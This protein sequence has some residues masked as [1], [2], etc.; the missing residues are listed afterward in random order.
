MPGIIDI[1]TGQDHPSI[2]LQIA[3]YAELAVNGKQGD[4][5]FDKESH[6]YKVNGKELPSVTTILKKQGLTPDYTFTDPWYAQRGTYIH[7]ACELW[8]QDNL[9]EDGLDNEIKPF[10]EGYKSFR[11]DYAAIITGHEVML[12]H[13]V[14]QYAGTIDI[15]IQYNKYYKLFLNDTG[16]YRLVPVENIRTHFNYFV[17]ALN[18]LRWKEQFK[19]EGI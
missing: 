19:K 10:L 5:E 4:L 6:I 12:W 13:P 14:Y 3:A 15:I 7:R 18:V 1:K 17:S 16:K 2:D 9:D 11:G 8:D